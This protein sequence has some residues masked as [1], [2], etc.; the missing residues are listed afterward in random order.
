MVTDGGNRHLTLR[1]KTAV[2]LAASLFAGGAV[3]GI[4]PPINIIAPASLS[5]GEA[6]IRCGFDYSQNEQAPFPTTNSPLGR[7]VYRLPELTMT[8]GMSDRV[9]LVFNYPWL[10]LK[11]DGA[12][13]ETGTGDLRITG[14]YNL[15]RETDSIPACS[16]IMTTKLP[17]ASYEK[18][19]GTDCTDFWTGVA[20]AKTA[21]S[22]CLLAN[23]S[24]G[25]IDRPTGDT[26][27]DDMLVY[28]IGA[29]YSITYDLSV[30][31]GLDGVYGSRL[32]NDRT[33][34]RGG[35]AWKT[36]LGTFDI[37]TGTGLTRDSGDLH[38][39]MGF[40]TAF[41]F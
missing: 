27:Q 34:V 13:L 33:I 14:I 29:I 11:Q 19:L 32:E 39:S 35:I 7:K 16:L 36:D 1:I 23:A 17:N 8:F 41:A 40:T 38:I 24:I 4:A 21:G 2:L 26:N 22:L 10:W 37:S 12:S 30:G 25:V 31:F 3:A 9:E 20:M 5:A 6:E 28:D 15:I 18:G